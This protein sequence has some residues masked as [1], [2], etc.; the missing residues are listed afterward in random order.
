[1]ISLYKK[2]VYLIG[3][4]QD[5]VI[6]YRSKNGYVLSPEQFRMDVRKLPSAYME[7]VQT[8]W[9]NDIVDIPNIGKLSLVM[10]TIKHNIPPDVALLVPQELLGLLRNIPNTVY[11]LGSHGDLL[12]VYVNG[13]SVTC[14][15]GIQLNRTIAI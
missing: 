11:T 9:D 3:N 5:F 7:Y 6:R 4:V 2:D 15:T 8:S 10:R 1:M 14:H 13:T 12:N